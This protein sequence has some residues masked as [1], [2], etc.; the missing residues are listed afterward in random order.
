MIKDS[1]NHKPPHKSLKKGEEIGQIPQRPVRRIVMCGCSTG[2]PKGR[3]R[4]TQDSGMSSSFSQ[5]SSQDVSDR[6]L[7]RCVRQ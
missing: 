4:L 7:N 6:K 5:W 1:Q 2:M 3:R